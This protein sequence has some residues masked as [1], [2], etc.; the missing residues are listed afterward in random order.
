LSVAELLNQLVAITY[1]VSIY[2]T[3]HFA[4]DAAVLAMMFC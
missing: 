2:A 4:D 1:R 3:P